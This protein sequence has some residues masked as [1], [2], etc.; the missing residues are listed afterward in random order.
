MQL[1]RYEDPFDT[2]RRLQELGLTEA[3]LHAAVGRG[4][5]AR[6][7][8]TTHHPRL[9]GPIAAWAETV[10]GL[11]EQLAAL[12]WTCSDENNFPRVTSQ[13]GRYSIIV[14]TGDELTGLTHGLPS[15]RA[16][17]GP[18][19]VD[20]VLANVLQLSLFEELRHVD[21]GKVTSDGDHLTWILLFY[22]DGQDTRY[23]LSLPFEI[24]E[25]GRIGGWKERIILRPISGATG[26]VEDGGPGPLGPNVDVPVRRK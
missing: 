19:T 1:L 8:C 10:G 22:R 21:H 7:E 6:I 16:A 14:Q 13:D 26:L 4:H 11:R 5:L 24:G 9:F 15:T 18:N 20:A 25:D 3:I 2:G 17:K 23:E 12:G